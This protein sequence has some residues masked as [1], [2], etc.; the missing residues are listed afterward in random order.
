[1]EGQH[2]IA[3]EARKLITVGDVMKADAVA[4][5]FPDVKVEVVFTNNLLL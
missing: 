5:A 4:I 1:L 3:V 2:R